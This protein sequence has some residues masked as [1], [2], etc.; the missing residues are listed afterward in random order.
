MIDSAATTAT[1]RKRV[2]LVIPM[3]NEAEALT[4]LFAR[5]DVVLPALTAYDFEIV[6]VND[7][8][9]D[10]TL[11]RLTALVASR[12]DLTVVDLSRNFGKEAALSAGLATAIGDA[13]IPLDADLQDPPEVIADML[14]QWEQGFEVV[15]AKRGDRSSDSAAKRFTARSFYRVHNAVADVKIPD[16]VGDF[17]LMD[18]VV[19]DALNA[20]P[21][22]RRFMKGLFAWVGF[23]TTTIEYRREERSAGTSKFNAWKLWNFALEGIASFSISP[24][25]IWTY[26]G[27]VVALFAMAW[28]GW[29]TLR[30]IVWGVDVPGYASLLV[31]VLLI[32]GLQLIGIG[33]IGEYL[34]RAFIESKRRPAYLIRNVMRPDR[35]P[36]ATLATSVRGDDTFARPRPAP[37]R[38]VPPDAVRLLIPPRNWGDGLSGRQFAWLFVATAIAIQIPVFLMP[39]YFSHDDLQWLFFS[40]RPVSDWNLGEL[41]GDVRQ[42]QYRPLT[43]TLWLSASKLLGDSAIAMH[44]LRG[45]FGV[46]GAAL[47]AF[48]VRRLG[49]SRAIAVVAGLIF[50]LTPSAMFTNGWVGTYADV[51]CLIFFLV[52]CVHLTSPS[53]PRMAVTAILT[54][55]MTSLAL[56]SKESALVFPALLASAYFFQRSRVL[57]TALLASSIAVATYLTL[58]LEVILFPATRVDGYQWSLVNIPRRMMEYGVFP[59]SLNRQETI[60]PFD[61]PMA[62]IAASLAILVLFAVARTGWRWLL[63]LVAGFY[64]A[65]GPVL[66]L[67]FSAVHY[68]YLATAVAV[69][70]VAVAWRSMPPGSR[71]AI[72][73]AAL[74]LVIHGGQVART[75]YR[76]S[77]IQHVLYTDLL[78]ELK[79]SDTPMA[80][81]VKEIKDNWIAD[82]LLFEVPSYHGVPIRGRVS[83][84]SVFDKTTIVTHTMD[85][86]GRLTATSR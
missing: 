44:V 58:R 75:M 73:L 21:E 6:C 55:A 35:I 26:L 16:D 13:V 41:F 18:R 1:N 28:G 69:G 50:L 77:S 39:G 65:L 27:V 66:I 34:G 30:T 31:A 10:D 51:L 80:V 85:S 49:V 38:V 47:L 60:A 40:S 54:F 14:A 46:A 37:P 19:V 7:G 76:V 74:V 71:Y 3:Y 72:C 2:S 79:R 70:V 68:A 43:F 23:R 78:A 63:A 15:L 52:I 56:L 45:I 59:F 62:W 11:A 5:L 64:V 81:Q 4:A 61:R 9:S 57:L 53:E 25:K 83:F 17:R 24:L 8:S 20:L 12:G 84:V 86:Q 22:S 36:I 42:F 82:R 32:G 67:P 33:M 48:C 29:I